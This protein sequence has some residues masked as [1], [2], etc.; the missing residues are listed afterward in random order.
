[1][2]GV[3]DLSSTQAT[4]SQGYSDGGSLSPEGHLEAIVKDVGDQDM[5]SESNENAS[6]VPTFQKIDQV[7]T[8]E[9]SSQQV[10]P[11]NE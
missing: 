10:T 3:Q 1:M 7:P 8:D 5:P 2:E 6:I 4:S 11:L 9:I